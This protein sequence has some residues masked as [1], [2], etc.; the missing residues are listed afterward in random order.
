M[1]KL[2][3]TDG[4]YL[5]LISWAHNPY[6]WLLFHNAPVKIVLYKFDRKKQDRFIGLVRQPLK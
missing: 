2:P 1:P 4:I 6:G 3:F 5:F